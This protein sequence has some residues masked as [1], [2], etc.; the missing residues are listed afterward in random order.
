[1]SD[2]EN[3]E[4]QYLGLS[5]DGD[6]KRLCIE[7]EI[8]FFPKKIKNITVAGG[9]YSIDIER[10]GEKVS[11]IYSGTAIF[12]RMGEM[13]EDDILQHSTGQKAMTVK[14]MENKLVQ[15]AKFIL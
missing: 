14:K 4:V 15:Q 5:R 10:D 1:M 6:S 3:I 9:F 11:S 7:G 13:S 2:N 12:L 8:R